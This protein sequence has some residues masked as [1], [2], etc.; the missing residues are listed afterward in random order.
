MAHDNAVARHF[1]AKVVFPRGS[2]RPETTI[3]E[4]NA[5]FSDR[6]WSNLAGIQTV[7]SRLTS[8]QHISTVPETPET[9]RALVSVLRCQVSCILPRLLSILSRHY[10]RILRHFRKAT[11][12]DRQHSGGGNENG[13][14]HSPDQFFPCGEKWAGNETRWDLLGLYIAS[15]LLTFVS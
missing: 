8:S 11:W 1:V 10:F 15:S 3:L 14:G 2:N 9:S 7:H 4:R 12:L 5:S 13:I 6:L